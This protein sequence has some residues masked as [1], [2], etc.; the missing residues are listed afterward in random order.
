M[1]VKSAFL[2][3]CVCLS[4]NISTFA[5]E[6]PN[7]VKIK[8]VDNPN[9]FHF[10][11]MG[12][13]TGKEEKGVF[14]QIINKVNI[15]SP[16]FVVSVGDNIQGYTLDANSANKM[17]DEYDALISKLNV[18]FLKTAGNHD[19]SNEM[20]A[21]VYQKRFGSPYYFSVYKNV[22][23][24]FVTTDDPYLA[25]LDGKSSKE[26]DKEKQKLKQMAVTQ[27]ITP[28]SLMQLKKY[29]EKHR[30]VNGGRI[31]DAQFEYFNQVLADYNNVRWTFVIMHKPLWKESAPPENW[32][33]I[34]NLLKNRP[35]TVF[36]GHEH[37]NAYSSRNNRDY[38]IM[39]GSGAGGVPKIVAGVYQHILWVTMNDKEPA[40]A[41]L[42]ADG[43]LE[44]NYIISRNPDPNKMDVKKM[45]QEY[46]GTAKK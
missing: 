37:I 19:I 12:D 21:D 31:S 5:A 16:A 23:F 39:S 2:L 14:E 33:K 25:A 42:M 44:K 8:A 24:L 26:L 15:M 6:I 3:V 32:V 34:E 22:L 45:I 10:V 36:A 13:R 1:K 11:V 43:I 46:E 41:N 18:P 38:I 9:D 4:I 17:W 7:E 27:G 29:E 30:N 40:I 28:Q 20:M 35:Y